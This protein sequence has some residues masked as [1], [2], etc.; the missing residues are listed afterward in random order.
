MADTINKRTA[1]SDGYVNATDIFPGYKYGKKSFGKTGVKY[2]PDTQQFKLTVIDEN[3]VASEEIKP[4]N[5]VFT[6]IQGSNSDKN[7][8]FLDGFLEAKPRGG[9]TGGT[10]GTKGTKKKIF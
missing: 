5:E 6:I 10:K 2:N 9:N 1:D 4:F 8:D 7:L 3:G